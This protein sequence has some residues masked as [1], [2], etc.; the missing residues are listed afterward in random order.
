MSRTWYAVMGIDLRTRRVIGV[1]A[2]TEPC[3][4]VVSRTYCIPVFELNV[5]DDKDGSEEIRN[6][7]RLACPSIADW[8]IDK[9]PPGQEVDS[10]YQC[11]CP[12]CKRDRRGGGGVAFCRLCLKADCSVL[13]PC[14]AR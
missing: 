6:G 2:F 11:A 7:F 12:G 10:R 1:E 5:D 9:P 14:K 8:W 13:G 4:T 3:P